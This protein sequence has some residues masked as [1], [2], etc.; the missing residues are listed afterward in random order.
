MNNSNFGYDRRNNIYNCK[1]VSIFDEYKEITFSNRY[2][3]I[4]DQKVSKF[5]TPDLLKHKVEEEFND[6][7]TKLDKEYRFYEIKLQII[8]AD[9]KKLIRSSRRKV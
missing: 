6:K 3:N 7:L 1:F 8:K 9:K 2:H 5:V 4:F